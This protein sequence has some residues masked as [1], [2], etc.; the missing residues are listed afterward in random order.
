[1]DLAEPWSLDNYIK[2]PIADSVKIVAWVL[3]KVIKECLGDALSPRVIAQTLE[4]NVWNSTLKL[5]VALNSTP[6]QVVF[7]DRAH[8]MLP[9]ALGNLISG[10]WQLAGVYDPTANRFIEKTNVIT[11]PRTGRQAPRAWVECLAGQKITTAPGQLLLCE[12]CTAGT[13]SGGGQS[14]SC[15]SCEP[16]TDPIERSWTL[17]QRSCL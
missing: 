13:A 16:G 14:T 11:W 6:L 15:N 9:M 7:D 1:L 12:N 10:S 4:N 3:D 17:R 8:R 5:S 2:G